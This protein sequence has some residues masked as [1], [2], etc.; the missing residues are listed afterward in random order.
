MNLQEIIVLI[1]VL[2]CV[3]LIVIRAGKYIQR[4]NEGKNPCAS[5]TSVCDLRK[6]MD[7]KKKDC[8]KNINKPEKN[9]CG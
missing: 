1:I 4:V 3:I 5:C 7:E 6:L 9:C 2:F 8:N